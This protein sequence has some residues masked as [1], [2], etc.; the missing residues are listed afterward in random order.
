MRSGA[1]R[2]TF[3]ASRRG[4]VNAPKSE[5]ADLRLG[6]ETRPSRPL[7]LLHRR[8]EARRKS[9]RDQAVSWV[10]P[11]R[12]LPLADWA[13][14]SYV[15]SASDANAFF[16]VQRQAG[17]PRADEA[18]LSVATPIFLGRPP[19][20][21]RPLAEYPPGMSP[22]RPRKSRGEASGSVDHRL[23]RFRAR[24]PVGSLVAAASARPSFS[25]LLSSGAGCDGGPPEKTRC[26]FRR[27]IRSASSGCSSSSCRSSRCCSGACWRSVNG[28]WNRSH[29]SA[30]RRWSGEYMRAM[31]VR[32]P[33]APRARPPPRTPPRHRS[34]PRS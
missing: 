14:R 29:A 34:P 9:S 25:H 6:R 33:S 17:P 22:V 30:A 1:S 12:S 15:S 26:P 23:R 18:A 32:R 2:A 10:L 16:A 5:K 31:R 3:R 21:P 13:V 11:Y 27:W 8:Q 7:R 20:T 24:L 4:P 19:K 28:A